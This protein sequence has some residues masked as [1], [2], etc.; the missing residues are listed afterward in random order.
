MRVF[1]S[2]E[3]DYYLCRTSVGADLLLWQRSGGSLPTFRVSLS[4]ANLKVLQ[5]QV[6]SILEH[7]RREQQKEGM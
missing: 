6:A 3:H 7:H 1:Q 5:Q 2:G 4:D